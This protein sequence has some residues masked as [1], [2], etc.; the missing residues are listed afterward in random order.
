MHVRDK[1]SILKW[2]VW[3]NGPAVGGWSNPLG[4][5]W[6]IDLADNP[7]KQMYDDGTHGD[8]VAGDSVF[9][10]QV[11]YSPGAQQGFPM[12]FTGFFGKTRRHH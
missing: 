8:K 1:D 9:T 7:D 10:R 2:G 4:N 3:I 12:S 11:F 5:D 6:G